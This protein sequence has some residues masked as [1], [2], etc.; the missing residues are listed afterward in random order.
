MVL[1]NPIFL[2]ILIITA[3]LSSASNN[4]R[5]NI[6]TPWTICDILANKLFFF[7]VASFATKFVASLYEIDSKL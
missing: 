7:T 4:Q 5:D 6:F 2:H 3:L 1:F